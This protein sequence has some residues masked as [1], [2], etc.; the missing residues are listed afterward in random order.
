MT[1]QPKA[2]GHYIKVNSATNEAE[3]FAVESYTPSG[4]PRLRKCDFLVTKINGQVASVAAGP[5]TG[6]CA[7]AVRN[8]AKY[9]AMPRG[10][11]T[12]PSKGLTI[13]QVYAALNNVNCSR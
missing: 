12:C 6:K 11:G 1:P 5:I 9:V 3:C 4:S 8:M 7:V 2:L 13:N 10:S